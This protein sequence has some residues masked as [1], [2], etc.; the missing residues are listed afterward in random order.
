MTAADATDGTP[1]TVAA[2]ISDVRPWYRRL[3]IEPADVVV[4]VLVAAAL[5][6]NLALD[7]YVGDRHPVDGWTYA[8]T[9]L[10]AAPL[11]IRTRRPLLALF[12]IGSLIVLYLATG[13]PI[14]PLPIVGL[15]ALYSVAAHRGRRTIVVVM[16]TIPLV[17]AVASIFVDQQEPETGERALVVSLAAIAVILGDAVR[18]RRALAAA[19]EEQLRLAELQREAEANERVMDERRRIARDLHDV[20]AHGISS[21]T[22]QAGVAAH[23]IDERPEVAR[24][25][26]EE[27]RRTG[28]QSLDELRATLRV[29]RDDD[30]SGTAPAPTLAD[31]GELV[32][33]S[34]APATLTSV[35]LDDATD[36]VDPVVQLV[37]YR[38]VQEALTNAAKHAP[39]A[40]TEVLVGLD[41]GA[42]RVSVEVSNPVPSRRAE[43]DGTGY[44]LVGMS[45][46]AASV[47]GSV[48]AGPRFDGRFVV[49]ADLPFRPV[50]AEVIG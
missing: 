49:A 35:G 12:A 3:G 19:Y 5:V 39:G 48:D 31:L 17:A 24:E 6:A 22:V 2:P 4:A 37:A 42:E 43:V 44:G 13:N 50:S 9:V 26:L 11:T 10:V 41:H 40:M 32:R 7:L 29:L 34:A 46:R 45:E 20:V 36:V 15:L 27:I 14:T 28:Q 18:S 25:S 23:V 16:A 33:T 1:T 21:I 47:G 8:L 30:G 38:I